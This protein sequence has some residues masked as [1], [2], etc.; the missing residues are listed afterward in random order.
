M[1][2]FKYI[3]F[4][5]VFFG[6]ALFIGSLNQLNAGE[7]L[8]GLINEKCLKECESWPIKTRKDLIS[9]LYAYDK[10]LNSPKFLFGQ[11]V[12]EAEEKYEL[13]TIEHKSIIKKNECLGKAVCKLVLIHFSFSA[14]GITNSPVDYDTVDKLGDLITFVGRCH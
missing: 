11:K 9:V 4:L 5:I 8:D 6:I 1:K 7:K 13:F 2:Y 3:L 10:A 14:S 12:S